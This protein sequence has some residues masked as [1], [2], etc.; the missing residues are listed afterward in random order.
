V[1]PAA[2]ELQSI[3]AARAASIPVVPE[4]LSANESAA[5][6]KAL[7]RDRSLGFIATFPSSGNASDSVKV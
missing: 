6:S 5:A 3:T 2:K 1:N 4:K 7:L